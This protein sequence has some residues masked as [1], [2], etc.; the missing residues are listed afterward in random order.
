MWT[1]E[2]VLTAAQLRKLHVVDLRKGLQALQGELTQPGKVYLHRSFT[3]LPEC[4]RERERDIGGPWFMVRIGHGSNPK[5][6]HE[7]TV[8]FRTPPMVL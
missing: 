8:G 1:D 6:P 2:G 7:L 3:L 5:S 4:K